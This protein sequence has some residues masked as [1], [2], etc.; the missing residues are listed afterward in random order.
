MGRLVHAWR[1]PL[2][3]CRTGGNSAA[4]ER[5]GAL[6]D[7][8]LEV[9]WRSTAA[10]LIMASAD[11]VGEVSNAGTASSVE[12]DLRASVQPHRIGKIV[13]VFR[14]KRVPLAV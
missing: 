1:T 9:L 13:W 11:D 14:A 6:D 8:R 12:V 2:W 5:N 4:K 10:G 3:W 7:A